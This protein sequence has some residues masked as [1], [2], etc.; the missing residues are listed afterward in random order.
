M[1]LGPVP[2]VAIG[3]LSGNL[4]T[5]AGARTL[6]APPP[7]SGSAFQPIQLNESSAITDL[8][9]TSFST[10]KTSPDTPQT[11]S[12]YQQLLLAQ[13]QGQS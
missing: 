7:A 5:G 1:N 10:P 12:F 3:T 8:T 9:L 2:L 6:G 11:A 4:P 13:Q